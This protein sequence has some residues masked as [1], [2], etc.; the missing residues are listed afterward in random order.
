MKTELRSHITKF[1]GTEKQTRDLGHLMAR[2]VM[3]KFYISLNGELGTGKTT[4][5]R[6]LIQNLGIKQPIKSPTYS[7]LETY[8]TPNHTICHF[9]FYRLISPLEFL[10][11]GLGEYFESD[12]ICIVEWPNVVASVIR[13]PDI[14]VDLQYSKTGRKVIIKSNTKS[15]DTWLLKTSLK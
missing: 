10:E 6:G 3:P 11:A 12:N 15:G 14:E 9:D 2:G 4:F 8:T 5:T 13:Q 7:L 1:L